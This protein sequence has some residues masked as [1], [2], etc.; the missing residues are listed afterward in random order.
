MRSRTFF[1]AAVLTG[2]VVAAVAACFTGPDS[3]PISDNANALAGAV[4]QKPGATTGDGTTPPS[5]DPNAICGGNP[6]DGGGCEKSWANDIFPQ[7]TGTGLNCAAVGTC[8]GGTAAAPSNTEPTIDAKDSKATWLNL[9]KMPV[10]NKPYINP[11][12]QDPATS[13]FVCNLKSAAEGGCGVQMPSGLLAD[14]A[15]IADVETWIKCGSPFN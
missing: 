3:P 15:F 2:L 9:Y 12:S 13:S 6:F 14:P 11:C 4:N 10:T 5:S 8:H 1:N 7:I